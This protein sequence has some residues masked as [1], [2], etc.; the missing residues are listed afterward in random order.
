MAAA[1]VAVVV[2]AKREARRLVGGQELWCRGFP[3][4]PAI[5]GLGLGVG[6]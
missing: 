6:E 1:M 2:V 4:Y 3:A 5:A